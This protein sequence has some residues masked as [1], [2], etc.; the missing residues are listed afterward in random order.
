MS[1]SQKV[2]DSCLGQFYNEYPKHN[3]VVVVER[4]NGE[5]RIFNKNTDS[6]I[7]NKRGKK[8]ITTLYLSGM[9]ESSTNPISATFELLP[10]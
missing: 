3:K 6:M 2:K 1:I 8:I 10:N 7:F 5:I 9:N 4:L